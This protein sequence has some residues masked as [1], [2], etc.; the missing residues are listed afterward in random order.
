MKI[1]RWSGS[2]FAEEKREKYSSRYL[3]RCLE[4]SGREKES[5][6]RAKRRPA[7]SKYGFLLAKVR[8]RPAN[9]PESY[10]SSAWLSAW[11]E[12]NATEITP[13]AS[14]LP[15]RLAQPYRAPRCLYKLRANS[16]HR[17]DFLLSLSL[18]HSENFHREP[19]PS[20][21]TTNLR[22]APT[23]PRERAWTFANSS[24]ASFLRQR[25][26]KSDRGRKEPWNR[27]NRRNRFVGRR[28]NQVGPS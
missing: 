15:P 11:P 17:V 28:K 2:R 20:L 23:E 14:I 6:S 10:Q 5:A 24:S 13:E 8:T 3:H 16:E 22:S 7:S 25:R 9:L 27:W 1:A 12:F 21:F 19:R 4:A 26:K 18:S